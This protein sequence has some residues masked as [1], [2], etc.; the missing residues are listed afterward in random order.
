MRQ[1]FPVLWK[2]KSLCDLLYCNIHFI[3]VVNPRYCQDLPILNI[4]PSG[5]L[6]FFLVQLIV[7]GIIQYQ[8]EHS[9]LVV[10]VL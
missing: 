3:V 2:P 9:P 4:L 5:L 7:F 8:Y 6:F 1:K 10:I